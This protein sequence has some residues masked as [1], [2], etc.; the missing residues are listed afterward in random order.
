M[1]E[2]DLAGGLIDPDDVPSIR[3]FDNALRFTAEREQTMS[4]GSGVMFSPF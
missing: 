3:S 2:G 1:R 4:E